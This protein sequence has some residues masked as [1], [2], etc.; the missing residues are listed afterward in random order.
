MT[1]KIHFHKMHGSGNDYI[2]INTL[3][4]TIVNP[5]EK[6]IHRSKYHTGIGS[7]GLVLIGKSDKADF[8]SNGRKNQIF[9]VYL[10]LHSNM[11]IK[12][13]NIKQSI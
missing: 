13:N 12:N 7:D 4:Y 2:Y 6:A 8:G 9:Y 5:E 3:K 11:R 1:Q 10:L